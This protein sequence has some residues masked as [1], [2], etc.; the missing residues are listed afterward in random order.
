M[1][2][3]LGRRGAWWAYSFGTVASFVVA[4]G[5]FRLGTWREG[6]VGDGDAADE[7][8]ADAPTRDG[9]ATGESEPDPTDD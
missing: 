7:N 3:R 2:P 5:W 6:I 8:P 9:S 4:V 1:P